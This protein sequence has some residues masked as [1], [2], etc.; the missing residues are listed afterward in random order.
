MNKLRRTLTFFL[1]FL[2]LITE[3][4]SIF[5]AA[6]QA[7]PILTLSPSKI[8]A[9]E[10]NEQI[11]V[12]ITISNITNLWGWR[13]SVAWDPTSLS[14]SNKPTQGDFLKQV[15]QTLFVA[16][17]ATPEFTSKGTIPDMSCFL[18]QEGVSASGNGV[19]ATLKFNVL[20]QVIDSPIILTNYTLQEPNTGTPDTPVHNKINVEVPTP[21]ATVTFISGNNSIVANAGSPQ[22]INEDTPVTLNGS[23]T[24]PPSGNLTFTWTIGDNGTKTLT[25]EIVTYTFGYPGTY[26][27]TLTATDSQG[28]SSSDMTQI[29]VL[30]KTPPVAKIS[31]DNIALGQIA[32][33]GTD[34]QFSGT[35][36]YDPEGGTIAI[37]HW[38]F[39]DGQTDQFYTTQHRY[40]QPGT[41][42]I[43]LTVT[44]TRGNLTSTDS[45]TLNVNPS[46]SAD[47]SL[48]QQTLS[49]PPYVLG[50]IMAI[51]IVVIIGSV[52]WLTGTSKDNTTP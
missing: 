7:T 46:D 30:D 52:F 37:Y 41:Y 6:G 39:G 4:G 16:E 12:K 2:F 29:T 50:V 36:S 9:T 20:K 31:I 13:I 47:P 24:M 33:T 21:S 11:V 43:N 51:T 8:T 23:K 44:D 48:Q 15:G 17:S 28:G 14:L 32:T 5:F 22:I 38:D 40:L 45:I 35:Q 3:L 49:L 1:I 42:N 27:V 34:I 10:L 18:M 26:N 19:L 25:G